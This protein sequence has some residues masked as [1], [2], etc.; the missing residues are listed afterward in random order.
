LAATQ[1]L[2]LAIDAT[3]LLGTR[4]GVGQVT[5]ALIDALAG[6]DDVDLAAYAV[7]W[8]GRHDL[9]ASLPAGVSAATAPFPARLTRLLWPKVA[10]PRVERW[11]GP[12]DVVHATNFVA[13][14]SRAPV[15]LTIH[16]LTVVHFPEMCTRDTLTYPHLI[17][18]AIDRGATIHTFSEFVANETREHFGVPAE[19]VVCIPPG[20]AATEQ[21]DAP[22]GRSRAGAD[23][24]VL[25]LGTVEPRKNLPALVR[26]FDRVASGDPEVSLVLAGPDG[27]GVDDL[28]E[29]VRAAGHADRIR[30]LPYQDDAQR[31]DLLAGASVLA[32]PSV[33]EGFG[34]PPLE[35]MRAGVPVVAS[36]AGPLP[37]VLGDAALLPDPRDIDAIADA[38]D[39]VLRD[40]TLRAELTTRG[41]ARAA[42]Y[43]WT[44]AADAFAAL[45]QRVA[46]G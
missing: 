5:A 31:R 32:Y 4:T 2:R 3:S 10:F 29:A 40:D 24:Y 19:R 17:R 22:L 42:R 25:A 18:V 35:A 46:A 26:A 30:R 43:T 21:G 33:Y 41:R 39:R 38:L 13:P 20:I 14:P 37:E 8:K 27:W 23:R 7:T 28:D 36:N 45:Y 9:A 1:Q 11:T 15:V 44:A 12:V 16:D 6:R 34:H